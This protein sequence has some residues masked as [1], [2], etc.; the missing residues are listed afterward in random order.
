MNKN[1]KKAIFVGE[2]M[3]ELNGDISSLGTSNSNMQVNFGGDTYNS[4]VYFKRL[5]DHKTNTFYCTAL[6]NDNFSKKMILR[7]KNEELNC[8]Y[9]RTDGNTPPGLYSIEIDERGERS[10]SYWRDHSPSKKIFTGLN[11]KNLIK[12]ISKADTFYYSGITL[13][14]LDEIQQKQLIEIGHTA[15]TSAFDLN[16]RNQLHSDKEKYK[17]LFKQINKSIDIHF[18]SYDDA[19]DLFNIK[20]PLEIFEILN[21]NKNLVLIRYEN[22]IIFRDKYEEIK[23]IKVPHGDV[24]DTTAAGDSFNGAFLALF[25]NNKNIQIEDNILKS[26]SITREVIKHKGA[27]ISKEFMPKLN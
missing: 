18:V 14:I 12:N 27:I 20:S 22:N 15:I 4:A 13:G 6:S 1:H 9:I 17:K 26:H 25:N 16:F 7:F 8:K 11:G 2:C 23:T 19:K 21:N 10:F 24:V 3:I 5:T